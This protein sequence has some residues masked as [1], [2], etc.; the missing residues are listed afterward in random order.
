M[1]FKLFQFVIKTTVFFVFLA[2]VAFQF[3]THDLDDAPSTPQ[4][5]ESEMNTSGGL[6]V[7]TSDPRFEG[8]D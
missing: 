3:L 8:N 2:W 1:L 6:I 5:A 4:A 7:P